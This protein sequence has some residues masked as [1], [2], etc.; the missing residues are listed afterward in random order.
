M[1]ILSFV[2]FVFI[3]QPSQKEFCTSDFLY[4]SQIFLYKTATIGV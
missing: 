4:T 3:F 2:A 1:L